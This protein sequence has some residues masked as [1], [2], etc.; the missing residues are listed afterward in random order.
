MTNVCHYCHGTGRMVD[1]HICPACGGRGFGEEATGARAR[2]AANHQTPARR[3][4]REDARADR[5]RLLEPDP[6]V[7]GS[8]RE[9]GSVFPVR[10][11]D[12]Y[13][14]PGAERCAFYVQ[15]TK[16]ASGNPPGIYCRDPHH[17][18]T[19]TNASVVEW[20]LVH[21]LDGVPHDQWL[22]LQ[23]IDRTPLPVM[24]CLSGDAVYAC[25]L[26]DR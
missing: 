7:G 9:I 16:A 22:Q 21:A 4:P 15:T 1:G 12:A 13:F 10:N 2:T 26:A 18:V 8:A 17:Q 24:I 19:M 5:P 11:G 20:A 25:W 6:R 3:R 23:Y 14:H